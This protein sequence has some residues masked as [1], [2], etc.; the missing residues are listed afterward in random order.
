MN[1]HDF[2]ARWEAAVD[3]NDLDGMAALFA[4]DAVFRSPAV[5]SPTRTAR[6]SKASSAW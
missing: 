1:Y 5:F 2:I 6:S 3:A 4:E